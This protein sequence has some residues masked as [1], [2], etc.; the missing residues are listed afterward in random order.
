MY[1]RLRDSKPY[2][3]A[4]FRCISCG[5]VKPFAMMDCGHYVSRN[6][7][8]LRWEPSNSHGECSRCNRLQGDH[9]LGYRKNLILKLGQEAIKGTIAESLPNDRKLIM[10]KKLGEQ[11]VLQLEAAK[12]EEKKW[13]VSE[14]Q[15]MYMYFAAL[16]LELKNEI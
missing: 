10:I 7:F 15:E 3:F 12:Y 2:R 1:I 5:D 6:C 13:S 11:R 8:K 9:L 4:A 16:V 14:L